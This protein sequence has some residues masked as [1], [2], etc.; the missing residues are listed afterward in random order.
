LQVTQYFNDQSVVANMEAA[1]EAGHVIGL[2]F[3]TGLDATAMTD[4]ELTTTLQSESEK[5]HKELGV[6][7]KFLRF[8]YDKFGAREIGIATKMGFVI[9]G[10]NLGAFRCRELLMILD[11]N[12]YNAN[13]G[14][15]ET[16]YTTEFNK[17]PTG[18]GR[19]ISLH[20]DLASVGAYTDT[21]IFSTLKARAKTAGIEMVTLDVCT[22]SGSAY[23]ESN[24]AS[25]TSDAD[26]SARG[27]S[28][29]AVLATL[30]AVIANL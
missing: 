29:M 18:K 9:T 7:P 24:G 19:Y 27:V 25:V 21:G 30:A 3:P 8:S 28:V 23:R 12:D 2:R 1:Y 13:R 22:A 4:K 20:H 17:A 16:A 26:S 15:I 10:W 5:I 6:Y 14:S 11:A